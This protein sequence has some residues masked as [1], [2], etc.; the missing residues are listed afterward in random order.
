MAVKLVNARWVGPGTQVLPDGT[1]LIPGETVIAISD[2]E[3]T[4]SDNWEKVGG[5]PSKPEDGDS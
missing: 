5:K 4:D 3:A 1:E 2:G